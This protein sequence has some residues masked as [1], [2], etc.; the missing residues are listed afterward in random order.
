MIGLGLGISRSG[1]IFEYISI[2]FPDASD[3]LSVFAV[4]ENQTNVGTVLT[5]N[6]LGGSLTFSI[7][8]TDASK[9]NIGASTG[10]LSFKSAPNYEAPGDTDSDNYYD[11]EVTVSNTHSQT[12]SQN[13]RVY[14]VDLPGSEVALLTATSL[15]TATAFN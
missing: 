12:V 15:L 10:I 14:V 5:S 2:I 1:I 3:L 6:P 7:S 8:G 11:F 13:V 9:F 4:Y